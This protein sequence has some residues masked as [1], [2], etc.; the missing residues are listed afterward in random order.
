MVE[1]VEH[2][3]PELGLEPL[4]ELEILEDGLVGVVDSR[5]DEGVAAQVSVAT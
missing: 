5:A 2:L 1:R 3:E 4:R